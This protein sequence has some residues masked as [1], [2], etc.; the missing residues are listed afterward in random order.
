MTLQEQLRKLTTGGPV[1]TH[2]A[3]EDL[4][5]QCATELD[6]YEALDKA[7]RDF[8]TAWRGDPRLAQVCNGHV[9]DA[10]RA[11][12]DATSKPAGEQ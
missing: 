12:N 3:A 11:L 4:F 9:R 5:E 2:I 10:V 6:R 1:V 8:R 7:G